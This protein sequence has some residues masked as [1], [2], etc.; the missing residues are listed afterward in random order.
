MASDY[1]IAQFRFV[2]NLLLIH[3]RW[4]YR[5]TAKL[6]L[7]SFYKNLAFAMTQFWFNFFCKFSAQVAK[8]N[9]ISYCQRTFTNLGCFLSTM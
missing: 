3:G 7:Y 8:K 5:R 4:N 1:A 6:V 9:I 2:K